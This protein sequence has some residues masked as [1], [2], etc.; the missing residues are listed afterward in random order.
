[1]ERRNNWNKVKSWSNRDTVTYDYENELRSLSYL[2]NLFRNT[3]RAILEDS[4]FPLITKIKNDVQRQHH[5]RDPLLPN[6]HCQADEIG[7]EAL[8]GS[9][10][11]NRQ[12]VPE[13]TGGEDGGQRG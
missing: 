1:M 6:G 11:G 4:Q 3:S 8:Q 13:A 7:R 2:H 10:S 9:T 12:V 5:C